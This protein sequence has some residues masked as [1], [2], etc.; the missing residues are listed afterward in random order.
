MEYI[1]ISLGLFVQ[2]NRSDELSIVNCMV[3]DCVVI[4]SW[5]VP[6]FNVQNSTN[7]KGRSL[8]SLFLHKV[9]LSVVLSKYIGFS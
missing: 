7:I 6:R 2:I 3:S 9:T 1:L 5:Y 8:Y 4:I